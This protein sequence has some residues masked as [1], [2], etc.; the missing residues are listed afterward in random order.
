MKTLVA[1]V[2]LVVLISSCTPI[3]PKSAQTAL[4]VIFGERPIVYAQQVDVKVS[5]I[6]GAWC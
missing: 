1:A 6:S 2:L 5:T 3:P 4:G